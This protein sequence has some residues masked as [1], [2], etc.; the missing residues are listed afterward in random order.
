MKTPGLGI[1]LD[2]EGTTSSI[3]FVYDEMF[4]FVRR[5]LGEF[6]QQN[7]DDPAVQQCIT[8]LAS[9]L[10]RGS[11]ESWL[12]GKDKQQQQQLVCAGVIELMDADVKATGLKQLQGLIWKA[13]FHSGELVAHVYEDVTPA[14]HA[15]HNEGIDVRI[16]S[17]GSIAAQQLFFGHSQYG[18]LLS[19]FNGHYDT[20][21]GNKKEAAS[22]QSIAA[23][24]GLPPENIL[25]IS[26]VAEELVAARSAGM[27]VVLSIRPGNKPVPNADAFDSITR[28]D[29]LNITAGTS[30]QT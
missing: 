23:D 21:T 29:Q 25:F 6:L 14:L 19:L 8:L 27:Q 3:S 4:P 15:W 30:S 12:G 17:S 20:T 1:L 10:D 26:D 16:Y 11:V 24:Y 5:A 2:I 7:W 28:F 9:D 22:Y 13:G 18:N